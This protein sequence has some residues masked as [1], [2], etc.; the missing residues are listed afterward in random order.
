MDAR[1]F[2]LIDRSQGIQALLHHDAIASFNR[3]QLF[4][5]FQ[6]VFNHPDT[7]SYINK[8]THFDQKTLLPAL[9]QIEDR[10]S[11]SVSLESRVPLLDYRIVDLVTSMPPQLKFKGGRSK[12]ILKKAIKDLLPEKVLD[13]KDK[14]G[15]PVPLA[16][17]M[18]GGVVR[19]FVGD[20]LISVQSLQ[21]GIYKPDALNAMFA[22][23]GVGGRQLWGA[24]SLEL[25]HRHYIDA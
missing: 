10:V 3:E 25:W 6:K 18:Q 23:Q 11:M 14:M 20:T 5:E 21:R 9:L 22:N 7:R 2:H 17:W 8:M 16:E 13:R 1:Y 15:F 24:L 4:S 19:D 12:H